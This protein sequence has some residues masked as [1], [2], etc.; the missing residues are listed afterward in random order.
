[1][2][3]KVPVT[4]TNMVEWVRR[5]AVAVNDLIGRVTSLEAFSAAPFTVS[6]VTLTPAPL[7]GS[8]VHGMIA[9]DSADGKLKFYDGTVWQALY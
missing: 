8:P 7:P 6:S 9:V 3:L 4:A 1:M 2:I 5:V